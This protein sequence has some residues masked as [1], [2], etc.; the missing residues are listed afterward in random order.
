MER[1]VFKTLLSS[2]PSSDLDTS[3]QNVLSKD[4]EHR[5]ALNIP[6]TKLSKT[7]KIVKL[8]EYSASYVTKHELPPV[9]EF[10]LS[11]FLKEKL[12]QRR[13]VGAKDVVFDQ[14]LSVILDIPML[15]YNKET[16]AFVLKRSE[17]R[18]STIK[19]LTP[20]KR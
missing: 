17:K 6:W 14:E 19:N 8:Q 15:L 9:L 5:V 16:N 13:I 18:V 2:S 4:V 20:K 1:N 3:L 11:R 10:T 7:E 12:D